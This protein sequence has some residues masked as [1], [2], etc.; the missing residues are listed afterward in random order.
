M[1]AEYPDAKTLEVHIPFSEDYAIAANANPEEGTYWKIDYRYFDQNSLKE[2]SVDHI[3]GRF[4]GAKA[5]D[6]LLRA[7]YDVHTGAIL[8]LPGKILAFI[9]SLICASLPVTGVYIWWGRR[10]KEKKSALRRKEDP[11]DLN[12]TFT[13]PIRS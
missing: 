8:G 2:V 6:K 5:A 10:S 9:A 12:N 1:L 4:P 3:Y 13:P 7:N 11:A